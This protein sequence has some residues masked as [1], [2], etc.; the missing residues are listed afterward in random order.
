MKN[1][2][3]GS[4]EYILLVSSVLF[5]IVIVIV[6]I[7]YNVLS[8]AAN[9]TQNNTGNYINILNNFTNTSG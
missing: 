4:L 8:P 5:F 1:K 6:I 2:A 7:K 9:N 3:Q